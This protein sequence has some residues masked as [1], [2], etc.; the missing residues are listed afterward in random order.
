VLTCLAAVGSAAVE[1]ERRSRVFVNALGP[2]YRRL[3]LFWH[4]QIN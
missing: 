3:D 4:V 1:L 2:W